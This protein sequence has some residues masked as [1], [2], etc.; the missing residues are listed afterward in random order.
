MRAQAYFMTEGPEI[1]VLDR[2]CNLV[3]LRMH[4]PKDGP[5]YSL[6]L[7]GFLFADLLL[8]TCAQK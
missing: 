3:T 8:H 7:L 4:A 6:E 2:G 5:G 1:A